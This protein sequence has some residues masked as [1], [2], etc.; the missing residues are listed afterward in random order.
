VNTTQKIPN[1]LTG[2]AGVHFVVSELSRRGMIALPTVRNTPGYDILAASADGKRHANIQV[3]TSSK[4]VSFWLTPPSESI[5]SGPE[6]YYVLLR[7]LKKNKC[8]EVFLLK[9]RE[10]RREVER[11]EKMQRRRISGG[12]RAAIRPSI[13]IGRKRRRQ[14]DR[15]LKAWEKW[16]L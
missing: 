4:R 6:D 7:W 2:V 10:A 15:W 12:T 3:K 16:K 14:A 13:Y 8:F 1:F 11:G 9:G 5:R